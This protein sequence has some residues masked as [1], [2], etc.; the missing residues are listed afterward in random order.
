MEGL[1]G[2]GNN[3]AE[4]KATTNA[5]KP[6]HLVFCPSFFSSDSAHYLFKGF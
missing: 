4:G 3:A 6:V 2:Y 1:H 5:L